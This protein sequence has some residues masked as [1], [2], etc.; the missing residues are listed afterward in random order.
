MAPLDG[1]A[2]LNDRVLALKL[3][4]KTRLAP[5]LASSPGES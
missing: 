3:S 1:I 5:L 4:D 2:L